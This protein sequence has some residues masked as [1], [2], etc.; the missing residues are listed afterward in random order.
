MSNGLAM[1]I[2]KYTFGADKVLLIQC[3]YVLF[4]INT[5]GLFELTCFF[6]WIS[7]FKMMRSSLSIWQDNDYMWCWTGV[8][9]LVVYISHQS[10]WYGTGRW[11][12]R[13]HVT[14]LWYSMSS[15][16]NFTILIS[17]KYITQA[18]WCNWSCL[19]NTMTC[20][21]IICNSISN[22]WARF[23]PCW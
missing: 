21:V 17:Y 1:C 7:F 6:Y 20:Q 2:S 5:F 15:F 12:T 23:L 18:Y 8:I 14:T 9:Y 10:L 3:L 16:M 22:H 19:D 11:I 13:L 4:K